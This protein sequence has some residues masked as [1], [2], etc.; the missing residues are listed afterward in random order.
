MPLI[1]GKTAYFFSKLR[2]TSRLSPP[3]PIYPV[4]STVYRTLVVAQTGGA[5]SF[6]IPNRNTTTT[7][8][9]K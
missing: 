7:R 3:A 9:P 5:Y 6:T 4:I 2:H 1:Q 8:E